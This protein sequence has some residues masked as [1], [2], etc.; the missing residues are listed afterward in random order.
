MV[1]ASSGGLPPICETER[2]K[3]VNWRA[4]QVIRLCCDSCECPIRA[5]L[6][7]DDQ[8]LGGVFTF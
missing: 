4:K 7:A 5:N 6:R 3:H 8:K 2:P 1:M